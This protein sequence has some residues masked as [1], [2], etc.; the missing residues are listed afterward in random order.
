MRLM[1]AR[2]R[3]TTISRAAAETVGVEVAP[4]KIAGFADR[5]KRLGLVE[6]T[7]AEQH[8]LVMERVRAASRVGA[9][10][11]EGTLLRLRVPI[12][13]PDR[14]FARLVE[15]LPWV[16]TP[17]F[18]WCS[19][20]LFA[21]YLGHR[22]RPR[23]GALAGAV[24]LYTFT[25]VSA[26][27]YV[28]GYLLFLVIGAV[29]ELGHGLTTKRYGGECTTWG[30]CCSTSRPHSTATPTT[31]ALRAPLASPVGDVRRSVDPT[32]GRGGRGDRLGLHGAGHRPSTA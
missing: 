1:T 29:H 27:D 24:S 3:P 19:A 13:D 18:V 23:A 4:A 7:P 30:S 26:W 10:R 14:L 6:R 25:G 12:G 28:L 16:W 32:P 20:A 21:V 11:V 5:R 17:A 2:G 22:A 15:R 9:R 31:L 8:V